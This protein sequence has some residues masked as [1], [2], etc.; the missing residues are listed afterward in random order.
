[1][2]SQLYL[3]DT[4][5]TSPDVSKTFPA[6]VVKTGSYGHGVPNSFSEPK[7]CLKGTIHMLHRNKSPES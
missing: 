2:T 4:L 7:I 1:M 6:S 3:L 5:K